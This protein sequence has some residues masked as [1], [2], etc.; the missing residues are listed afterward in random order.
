VELVKGDFDSQARN[1]GSQAGMHA[2][3][4]AQVATRFAGDVVHIGVGVLAF[5]AVAEP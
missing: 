3:A 2:A 5:I 4:K 1:G